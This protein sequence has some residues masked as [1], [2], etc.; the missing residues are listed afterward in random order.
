VE[1]EEG[2]DEGKKKKKRRRRRRKKNNCTYTPNRSSRTQTSV[3]QLFTPDF[4][5]GDPP[6]IRHAQTRQELSDVY[7]VKSVEPVLLCHFLPIVRR[8]VI[9]SVVSS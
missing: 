6:T 5:V 9:R 8:A 4:S 3:F 1:D 2:E 7:R